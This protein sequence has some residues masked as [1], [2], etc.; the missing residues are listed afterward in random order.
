MAGVRQAML[1]RRSSSRV[2]DAAP[3]HDEL[4]ALVE[5][6]GQLADHSGLRPW[7][8]LELRGDDRDRLGDGLA[9]AEGVKPKHAEKYRAKARRAPL[10]LAVVA[11][12][13]PKHKVPEW[14]QEAVASGVA[15]ALSLVLDDEGWGV[16]WR[17]GE[18]T[19][20]KAV[21]KAHKLGKNERLLGW[22]YVGG[23]P[24]RGKRPRAKGRIKAAEHLG[25]L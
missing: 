14:E 19:R 8:I 7:R 21:H 24:A 22:L 1:A 3:T 12:V 9:K 5:A 2:T 11:S 17:T 18:H 4:L 20:A 6:A 15:H 23:L 13:R 10:V 16:F 25:T